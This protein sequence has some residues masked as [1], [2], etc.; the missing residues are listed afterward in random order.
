[1]QESLVLSLGREDT[2]EKEMAIS[3]S[4]FLLGKSQ[5]QRSLAG[6]GPYCGNVKHNL[7]TKQ[8]SSQL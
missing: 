1:M 6:Y 3:T 4:I 8:F 2:L 5:G 7:A